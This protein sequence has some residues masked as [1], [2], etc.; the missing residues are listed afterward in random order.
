MLRVIAQVG[1]LWVRLGEGHPHAESYSSGFKSTEGSLEIGLEGGQLAGG[2]CGF[3]GAGRVLR[4]YG[5]GAG[6][7][8]GSPLPRPW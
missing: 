2:S 7:V 4:R 3:G 1:R 5:T 8:R 6:T